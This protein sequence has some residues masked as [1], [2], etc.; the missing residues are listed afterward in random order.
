M[1]L[2]LSVG[3]SRE[4]CGP[5]A[6][7]RWGGCDASPPRVSSPKGAI[8]WAETEIRKIVDKA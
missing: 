4:R 6:G 2:N 8:R 5:R 7:E 1:L 3:L